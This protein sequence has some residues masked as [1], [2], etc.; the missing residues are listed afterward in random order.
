MLKKQK[1]VLLDYA[2]LR[3]RN[4]GL[5]HNYARVGGLAQEA[6]QIASESASKKAHVF[7]PSRPVGPWLKAFI[8]YAVLT[9]RK[10]ENK[11]ARLRLVGDVK[12][13][14]HLAEEYDLTDEELFAFLGGDQGRID[15]P[16]EDDPRLEW[17]RE[18]AAPDDWAVIELR[19]QGYAGEALAQEL[20][21]RLGTRITA[22][23]AT[24]RLH[25]A[26]QRLSDL[27]RKQQNL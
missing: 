20:S 25:R 5:A 14:R 2:M 7:D 1:N 9:L 6:V 12:T 26:K 23:A 8:H 17:I 16:Q 3:I 22:G 21:Q 27:Y 4:A 11:Q 18:H 15:E 13:Q 24:V 10:R 19:C